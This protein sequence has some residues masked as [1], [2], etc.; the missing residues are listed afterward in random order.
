MFIKILVVILALFIGSFLNVVIYR[1]PRQE[2]VLWPGSHCPNCNHRLKA[3]DLL[4]LLSFLRLK[5]RCRYCG[6]LISR[7]YPVVEIITALSCWLVYN[8]WGLSVETAVGFIFTAFL[9]VAAFIDIEH[10]IIPDR[11]TYPGMLTGLILSFYTIGLKSALLGLLVFAAILLGAA[12]VSRGGM[13]GGDVKLA[14]VIGAFLGYAGS[15]LTLFIFSLLGGLWAAILLV[16]GKATRKTAIKF[17]PFFS[18]A[19]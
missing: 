2:S 14:G 15:I 9:I 5:G 12:V 17:W 16:Q 11:V 10:G 6:Q 3:R 19:A 8:Q 18:V 7:R 4:P 1:V 13:G